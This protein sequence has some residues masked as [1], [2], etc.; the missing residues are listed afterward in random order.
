MAMKGAVISTLVLTAGLC[1]GASVNAESPRVVE[2]FTS[3]SCS[4]C[5]PAEAYLGE[6]AGRDGVLA[7][8]WHVDYWDDLVYGRAGRWKD[9]FSDPSFTA[10]QRDYNRLIR[11]TG[12]V[13]TPQMIINGRHEMVGSHP[14]RVEAALQKAS[15]PALDVSVTESADGYAITVGGPVEATAQVFA[16]TLLKTLTTEVKAGENKGKTLTNHNIVRAWS[17][18]GDHAGGSSLFTFARPEG[19]G[20]GCAVIV[21]DSRTA[22]VLGAAPC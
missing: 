8:E 4:S 6:L 12:S 14:Y 1:A 22:A 19:E 11:G 20:M 15:R 5:P 21:Q 16:A 17:P 18:L 10:R 3:Q 9:P 13:Y 2:L 7:L